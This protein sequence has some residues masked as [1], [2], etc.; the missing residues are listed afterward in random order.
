MFK[1]HFVQKNL[2]PIK[3]GTNQLIITYVL[4]KNETRPYHLPYLFSRF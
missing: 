4:K 1:L 2:C 3:Q